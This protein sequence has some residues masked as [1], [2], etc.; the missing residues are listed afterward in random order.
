[1]TKYPTKSTDLT[2]IMK[3]ATRND[4]LYRSDD[5]NMTDPRASNEP[6]DIEF[7]WSTRRVSRLLL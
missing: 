5:G 3:V 2:V 7:D 6:G 1:M 4:N